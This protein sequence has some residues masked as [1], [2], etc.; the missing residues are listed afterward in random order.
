MP[1]AE[2][3]DETRGRGARN[4]VC[5]FYR[6]VARARRDSRRQITVDKRSAPAIRHGRSVIDS[7]PCPCDFLRAGVVLRIPPL[8]LAVLSASFSTR[9]TRNDVSHSPQNRAL[10]VTEMSMRSRGRLTPSLSP[11]SAVP[12]PGRPGEPVFVLGRRT[13]L[14]TIRRYH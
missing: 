9:V 14:R 3:I 4:P 11:P 1:P 8:P 5:P 7:V 13:F 12:K 10:N 6:T 2:T